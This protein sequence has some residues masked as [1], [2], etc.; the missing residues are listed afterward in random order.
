MLQFA[1][2]DSHPALVFAGPDEYDDEPS[3]DNEEQPDGIPEFV[4]DFST[5]N[6]LLYSQLPNYPVATV[7]YVTFS[8]VPGYMLT[9]PTPPDPPLVAGV[10]TVILPDLPGQYH[11]DALNADEFDNNLTTRLDFNFT[12][13]STWL[14]NGRGEDLI[15]GEP[16]VLTVVPEPA[17]IFLLGVAALALLRRGGNDSRADSRKV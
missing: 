10:G 8:R 4:F 15:T 13:P 16:L 12:S 5:I 17:S 14:A 2:Q 1:F 3:K 7:I 6:P 11:I 9:L